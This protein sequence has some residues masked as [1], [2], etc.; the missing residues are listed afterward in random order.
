[1]T[2]ID[3]APDAGR[4]PS[5][6]ALPASPRQVAGKRR[7]LVSSARTLNTIAA[8]LFISPSLI[9]FTLFVSVPT[10]V[11]FGLAFFDWNLFGAPKWVGLDNFVRL[12]N[13]PDVWQSL[14]VTVQFLAF[15]GIPTVALSFVAAALLD[16]RL[17]GI[18]F[19]R[20]FYFVPIIVSVAVSGVVWR[21]L[22]APQGFLNGVLATFGV[23][24]VNWTLDVRT[25]LP[26]LALM[27][28]W[29]SM[30]VMVILYL[31]AMQRI[32]DSLYEAAALDGAGVWVR[33]WS[34]IWP[35]VVPT[36]LLVCGISVITFVAGALEVPLIMTGGG[37][38]DA[39]RSLALYAYQVVFVSQEVGYGSALS[40]LQ[41][42][43]FLVPATLV[44]I[45]R[46][47]GREKS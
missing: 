25:A 13:D 10:F 46:R 14:W 17:R 29:L 26:A 33:L 45:G 38:L 42:A 24:G 4:A 44:L 23:S 9:A 11:A 32:P 39:T 34:I 22:Y 27:M 1:M 3:T 16:T 18:S 5:S 30:P 21:A 6:G 7:R 19:I 35:S 12:A 31:A 41:L 8:A 37:P 15:G 43:L 28:I 47:F 36:T 40:A 20:V 2:N